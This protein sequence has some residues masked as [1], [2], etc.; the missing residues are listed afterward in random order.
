MHLVSSGLSWPALN[1]TI[2]SLRSF[3]GVTLGHAE[4]P[5][6]IAYAKAPAKLPTILNGDEIVRFLEG[7]EPEDTNGTDYSLCGAIAHF[8]DG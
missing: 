7:P 1:Q 2:C 6:R 5:E 3:F 4:I 8:R